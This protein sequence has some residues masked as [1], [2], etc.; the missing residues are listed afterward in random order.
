MDSEV[1]FKTIYLPLKFKC[2][3]TSDL[4]IH[5]FFFLFDLQLVDEQNRVW[6]LLY[7]LHMRHFLKRDPKERIREKELYRQSN[8]EGE[9]D[10]C[11]SRI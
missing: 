10:L 3:M 4:N 9:F 6:L 1:S 2:E 7:D 5:R 11:I 8:V